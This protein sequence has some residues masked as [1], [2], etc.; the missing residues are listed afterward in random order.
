MTGVQAEVAEAR[1]K[2]LDMFYKAHINP[3]RAMFLLQDLR[4]H[5][6]RLARELAHSMKYNDEPTDWNDRALMAQDRETAINELDD[7]LDLFEGALTV[8]EKFEPA[9]EFTDAY[10]RIELYINGV[11]LP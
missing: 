2:A 3:E 4:D 10:D 5:I 6:N 1:E 11:E 7:W 8:E 9:D